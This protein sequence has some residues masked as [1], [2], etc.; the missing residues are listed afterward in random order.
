MAYSHPEVI[1]HWRPQYILGRVQEDLEILH[2]VKL[3]K[4][5]VYLQELNVEW[6][7][8][9]PTGEFNLSVPHIGKASKLMAQTDRYESVKMAEAIQAGLEPQIETKNWSDKSV[10][11]VILQLVLDDNG[12]SMFQSD[13]MV[14]ITVKVED[15]EKKNV[16]FPTT[17]LISTIKHNVIKTVISFMKIDPTKE[18]WGDITLSAEIKDKDQE[19]A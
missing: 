7:Y 11:P 5:N 14:S 6:M 18:G 16:V 3:E 8:S 12:L 9:N 17:P 2:E 15:N 1:K 10:G 13:V 19:K 4:I